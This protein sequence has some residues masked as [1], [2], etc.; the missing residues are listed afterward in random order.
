MV[1]PQEWLE[2]QIL[3]SSPKMISAGRP[4]VSDM[5]MHT[6]PEDMDSTDR[7]GKGG[8]RVHGPVRKLISC[9]AQAASTASACK[10]F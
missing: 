6:R 10:L 9:K 2:E 5:I 1:S 3:D 7:H 4:Q 8:N